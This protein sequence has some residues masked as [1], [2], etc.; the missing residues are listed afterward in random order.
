VSSPETSQ[1][2]N[3]GSLDDVVQLSTGSAT[4]VRNT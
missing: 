1:G 4:L 2:S 3:G